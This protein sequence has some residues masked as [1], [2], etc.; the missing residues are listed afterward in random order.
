M[1]GA[2]LPDDPATPEPADWYSP[3]ELTVVRLSSKSHWDVPI[4]VGGGIV[5]VLASHPTP[6]VFDGPED[7]NGLRNAD[8]IRFWADY[9][10]SDDT[11]GSSTTRGRPEASRP[12]PSS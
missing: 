1:P 6:P 8:E 3:E 9:I 12:M 11:A 7:R 2:R 10:A 5:H 4:D